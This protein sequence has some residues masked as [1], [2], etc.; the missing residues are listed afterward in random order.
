MLKLKFIFL[1]FY[2]IIGQDK[3][4]LF[5]SHMLY[6]KPFSLYLKWHQR[7]FYPIIV[8]GYILSYT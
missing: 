3:Y 1:Y 6:K 4:I 7:H 5:T 2:K 8:A